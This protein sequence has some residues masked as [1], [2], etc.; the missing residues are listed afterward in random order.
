M[1]LS[2]KQET[3]CREYLVDLNGTQAAIRAGYSART[4]REQATR[5]L[6]NVHIRARVDEMMAARSMRTE[7]TADV[8]I[9]ELARI[10]LVDPLDIIDADDA[11]VTDSATKDQRAAIQSIKVKKRPTDYGDEIEREV[12]LHDKV[13]ALD[14]LGKHLGMFTDK[15][16]ITGPGGAP[17]PLAI[18]VEYVKPDPT[19]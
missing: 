2:D 6:A 7:I 8:V 14:L 16:E 12:K 4:A 18:S 5:L 11:T 13:K 3:F 15:K 1:A 9:R 19:D 17:I 10:A